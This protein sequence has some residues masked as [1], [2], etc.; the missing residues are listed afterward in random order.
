[1][2][3]HDDMLP[4]WL[5]FRDYQ[6]AAKETDQVPGP[7][8][9][10]DHAI[11]VP[12]LGLAGEAG[13]LLTEFKKW[14]RQGEIY[15]PFAHQVSEEIGD[16][17]WYLANIAS[18]M[19]LDL[20][21]IA[22]ENLAKLEDRYGTGTTS[23]SRLFGLNIHRYDDHFAPEEQLPKKINAE[24]RMVLEAGRSKLALAI[25]GK[26]SG[27]TLTDNAHVDDGYRFH[28]CFHLTLATVL[29]WS[30]ILRKLLGCKRK[31]DPVI[32]EVE[33]GAR[34]KITEE[35]VSAVVYGFAKDYSMFDGATAVE[36]EL[37]R[38]IR[39]MTR[40]FEVRDRTPH[41]WEKAILQGFQAWRS[42]IKHDGG[43]LICDGDHGTV[44]YAPLRGQ[45]SPV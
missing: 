27:D 3:D 38:T 40:Q 18:K 7:A 10:S 26:L 8:S 42:L 41:E 1:M 25:D 35:A 36:Y 16:I 5:S 9:K 19:D 21:E 24:F 6:T 37:L 12:L 33:D 29:G 22:R 20:E 15:R 23:Q 2:N 13:S 39:M 31:S 32:D 28:D 17:L 4:A 14:L 30:P 44:E 34:A 11:M 45:Q 43:R